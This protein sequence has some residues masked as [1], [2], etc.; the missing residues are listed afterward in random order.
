LAAIA[1]FLVVLGRW[2]RSWNYV[3]VAAAVFLLGLVWKD[4]SEVLRAGWMKLAEGMGFVSGKVV[5]TLVYFL[6]LIP[7]AFFAKRSGKLNIRLKPDER[8]GFR[9]RNH[10]FV[11]EDFEN[12]W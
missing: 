5:L 1:L 9:V 8:W 4:F 2:Q 3:W 11:K 10:R 12:P 6:V 7:V